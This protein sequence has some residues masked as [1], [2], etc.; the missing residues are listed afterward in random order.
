MKANFPRALD[1][2][3]APLS[4]GG[5]P[6]AAVRLDDLRVMT[7]NL[8]AACLQ[9]H[10]L[11][12][13][14]ALDP[15]RPVAE[16][17]PELLAKEKKLR[18]RWAADDGQVQITSVLGLAKGLDARLRSV[19]LGIFGEFQNTNLVGV[20][21]NGGSRADTYEVNIPF[22]SAR[23]T[24]FESWTS[25][26]VAEHRE[27]GLVSKKALHAKVDLL[28]GKIN[29]LTGFDGQVHEADYDRVLSIISERVLD[30]ATVAAR[31]TVP[32]RYGGYSDQDRARALAAEQD[33]AWHKLA[34]DEAVLFNALVLISEEPQVADFHQVHQ[35]DV[36]RLTAFAQAGHEVAQLNQLAKVVAEQARELA[37]K[38]T[39][40]GIRALSWYLM[41]TYARTMDFDVE[42]DPSAALASSDWR[43][44]LSETAQKVRDAS[45]KWG[46]WDKTNDTDIKRFI[47]RRL[48]ESWDPVLPRSEESRPAPRSLSDMA[49]VLAEGF[50]DLLQSAEGPSFV[51]RAA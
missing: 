21:Q 17:L 40:E 28:M 48:D 10:L 38:A 37:P 45:M 41:I 47:A 2:P 8:R 51:Q 29:E 3:S 11:V 46:E 34:Q 22:M 32:F 6:A 33:D 1:V 27:Q 4:L 50:Y 14:S 44:V 16:Q 25:P 36:E 43:A 35:Q 30:P 39:E 26:V 23:R 42:I 5:P 13:G 7:D 15:N 19:A 12:E 9:L 49:G 18:A 31:E 24:V 20:G